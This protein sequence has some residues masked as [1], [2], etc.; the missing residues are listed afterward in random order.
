MSMSR[1]EPLN[2]ATSDLS[3]TPWVDDG[4]RPGDQASPHRIAAA[5]PA[6]LEERR[7]QRY[8]VLSGFLGWT[9]DAF[10]F[11]ILV[12]V[13]GVGIGEDLQQHV[14]CIVQPIADV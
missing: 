2:A 10:D 13:V 7:N 9:F 6:T 8:A 11:F 3:V 14:G 1:P 4:R 5:S 12:F